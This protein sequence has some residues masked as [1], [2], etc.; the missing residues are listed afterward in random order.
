MAL[1]NTFMPKEKISELG[2]TLLEV[3]IVLTLV[4][5]IAAFAVFFS[6]DMYRRSAQ[7]A[8]VSTILTLLQTAR[9]QAMHNMGDTP[10]GVALIPTGYV[11]FAGSTFVGSDPAAQMLTPISYPLTIASTSPLEIVFA[12][13]SGT[14]T[15]ATITFTDLANGHNSTIV[16]TYEGFI[17]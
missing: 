12:S 17:E 13:R 3:V 6:L 11:L 5:S 8:E 14:T 7:L 1:P 2:F 4:S 16:I 9:A 10:H 15:P